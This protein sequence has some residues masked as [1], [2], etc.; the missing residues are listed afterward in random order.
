[1]LAP[2]FASRLLSNRPR[3]AQPAPDLL[4]AVSLVGHP[5]AV[6]GAPLKTPPLW[7]DHFP[8]AVRPRRLLTITRKALSGA[9]PTICFAITNTLILATLRRPTSP[10]RPAN[11]LKATQKIQTEG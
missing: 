3:P 10:G 2:Q 7:A 4:A 5:P 6:G 1:C 9:S 11:Q 8:V